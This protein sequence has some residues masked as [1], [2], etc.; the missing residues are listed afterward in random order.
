MGAHGF[1]DGWAGVIQIDENVTRVVLRRVGMDVD[2]TALPVANAEEP[3]SGWV[4]Q[5]ASGPQP[6]SRKCSSGLGVNES[7]EI[8]VVRHG[9]E[10]A[11]QCLQSEME[12]TVVHGPNSGTER[13]AVQ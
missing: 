13:T 6:L 11:A 3:D 9:R 8:E 12:S 1:D 5:L 7:N 2:V 4:G 10:L